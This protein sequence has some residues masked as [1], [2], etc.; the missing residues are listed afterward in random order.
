MGQWFVPGRLVAA[1][2]ERPVRHNEVSMHPDTAGKRVWLT[3]PCADR[4]WQ[5]AVSRR[6]L[7]T[8]LDAIYRRPQPSAAAS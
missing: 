5:A 8:F 7:G 6:R 3:V 1:G 2:L 4:P